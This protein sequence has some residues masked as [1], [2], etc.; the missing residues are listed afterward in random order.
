MQLTYQ[1]G[2][3]LHAETRRSRYNPVVNSLWRWF[4]FRFRFQLNTQHCQI[5]HFYSTNSLE[6]SLYQGSLSY[7]FRFKWED[8]A[9]WN[10]FSKISRYLIRVEIRDWSLAL[11]PIV[12]LRCHRSRANDQRS[13]LIFSTITSRAFG[14]SISHLSSLAS[15][16]TSW[17]RCCFLVLAHGWY[18]GRLAC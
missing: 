5:T 1:F 10:L 13:V 3:L 7:E 6:G 11:P 8:T 15:R 14:S 9:A 17:H 16:S 4:R 12:C 18:D 2:N